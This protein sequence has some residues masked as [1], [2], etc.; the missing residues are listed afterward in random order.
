MSLS[1]S[2]PLIWNREE[3]SEYEEEEEEEEEAEETTTQDAEYE[4]WLCLWEHASSMAPHGSQLI[5][6]EN[7]KNQLRL[8]AI[9]ILTQARNWRG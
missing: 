8:E 7:C 5:L 3:G 9:Q 1:F 6:S 2:H 4:H